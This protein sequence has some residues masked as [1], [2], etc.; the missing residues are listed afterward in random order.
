M[1][2]EQADR[3]FFNSVRLGLKVCFEQF[4]ICFLALEQFPHSYAFYSHT[5]FHIFLWLIVYLMP[6]K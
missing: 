5:Y 6:R 3:N 2:H 4:S 1:M